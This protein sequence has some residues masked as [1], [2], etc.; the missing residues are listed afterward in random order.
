MSQIPEEITC[1]VFNIGEMITQIH[2]WARKRWEHTPATYIKRLELL[3]ELMDE[4][5]SPIPEIHDI[6]DKIEDYGG[7][8]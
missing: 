2:K 1:L 3:N 6:L 5:G 8:E 4:T 7:E